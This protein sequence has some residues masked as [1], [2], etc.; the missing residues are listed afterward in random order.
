VQDRA[1]SF[2]EQLTNN[3]MAGGGDRS[4]PDF[5]FSR[6]SSRNVSEY[7]KINGGLIYLFK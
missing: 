4:S 1:D 7:Q 3:W 5:T 6:V 2:L